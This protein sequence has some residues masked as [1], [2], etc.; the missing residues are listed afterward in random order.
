MSEPATRHGHRY[1]PYYCEENV[2]HLCGEAE[3]AEREPH[4][5]F[6]TNPARRVAMWGQRL[7]EDPD[8]PLAWDY[9]VVFVA[10]GPASEG[11]PWRVWDLDGAGDLITPAIPWLHASFRGQGVVPPEF[12]PSFRLVPGPLYQ[13]RFVS[14]RSHMRDDAGGWIQ[15]PP[16]WP[17]LGVVESAPIQTNLDAFLDTRALGPDALGEVFELSGL[18]ARLGE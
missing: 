9:H 6:I 16:P 11:S 12:R 15:P 4:A 13:A 18:A 10:R 8:L 17:A 2:W 14:D 3:F 1:W 7:A 5:L